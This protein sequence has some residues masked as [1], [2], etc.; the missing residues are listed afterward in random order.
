MR[1]DKKSDKGFLRA[2][3]TQQGIKFLT[4][5]KGSYDSSEEGENRHW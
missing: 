2:K 4:V 3:E 5:R 1:I